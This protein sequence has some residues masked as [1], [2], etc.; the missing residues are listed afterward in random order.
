VRLR[1]V[2]LYD[3]DCRVCR[4]TARTVIALDRDEALAVLPLQDADAGELLASLREDER[5]ETWRLARLDGSLTGYGAGVPE[6]LSLTR[7]GRPAGRLLGLVP[8]PWLDACYRLVARNRG[9]VGRLV[10]DGPAPRR[11]P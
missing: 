4:F 1:P 7:V 5:L 9:R 11:F 3:A 2:V 8:T 6:L 10:P